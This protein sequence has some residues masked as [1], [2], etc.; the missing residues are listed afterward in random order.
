MELLTVKEAQGLQA[1]ISQTL[2]PERGKAGGG[3]GETSANHF[4]SETKDLNKIDLIAKT[5]RSVIPE[6]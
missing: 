5:R 3:F 1:E 6:N 4:K 2:V